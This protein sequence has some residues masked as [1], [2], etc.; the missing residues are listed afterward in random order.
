M[1]EWMA[2]EEELSAAA[3]TVRA[4]MVSPNDD[5]ALLWDAF[6]PRE[7]V[8]SVRFSEI[9]TV[10][11][12][13]VADRREW[14]QRGRAI[15]LM[16][17]DLRDMELVPIEATFT[18]G[19]REIQTLEER[20][21]GNQ[22]LFREI[23]GPSIPARTDQLVEADYRRIEVDTFQAWANRRVVAKDPQTGREF[24]ME[25]PFAAERYPTA[26]T[27]WSDGSV[28]AFDAL[29]EFL[30][31][32]VD[33][34]GPW[35]GVMLRMATYRAIKADAPNPLGLSQVR[36]SRRQIEEMIED[37]FGYPFQFYINESTAD[38]FDDGGKATT[39]T[40]VWPEHKVAVVPQGE[41]V[42]RTVFAPVARAFEIARSSPDAGIDVRG[43]TVYTE[44]S[45][46]GRMLTVEAQVNAAP[47]PDENLMFVIDAGV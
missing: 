27:P 30:E 29:L 38:V 33:Y 44:Q 36:P 42:G 46:G 22:A 13:P 45:N 9:T 5:G 40:K 23:V 2:Q 20:T 41:R 18:I 14:N 47:V 31:M 7:N 19:E 28:N 15:P 12:R 11:F 6:M 26:P 10:D 35:Q 25:Y 3:L 17:P 24:T 1:F 43:V 16:T 39:R 4:Q 8:D 32:A 37:Q 34:V 21:F